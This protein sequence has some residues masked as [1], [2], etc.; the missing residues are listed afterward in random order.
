MSANSNQRRSQV[1][2][3]TVSRNSQIIRK[4]VDGNVSRS[5]E[6]WF[7]D[8]SIVL[9]VG[10]IMFRVHQ[11]VL[12]AHSEVFAGLFSLPQPAVTSKGQELIEGCHVVQ[13]HDPQ[14]DF[15]DLLKA[16]YRPGHLDQPPDNLEE[17]LPWISG[18]LR[19]STK[20]LIT[21]PRTR[22]ITILKAKFPV[23]FDEYNTLH[24][25]PTRKHYKSDDVMRAARLA[26]E[27]SIREILPY[28]FYGVARMGLA[29]IV[30]DSQPSVDISWK[31]KAICL[32]G[33][34]RLRWAE[35]SLSHS[36][37]FAFRPSPSCTTPQCA[38]ARGPHKEW[39]ILEAARAPNPLKAWTKWDAMNVC[40]E[41]VTF[42]QK[43]HQAGREEVW[44]HLPVIFELPTWDKL[45]EKA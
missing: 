29:R 22:C 15:I 39:R 7:H 18:I 21:S 2:D 37:L 34:E 28:I 43:Q 36:F 20:Y 8:G 32:V 24:A 10:S 17:L 23:T 33:R 26:Q 16:I 11:T 3:K 41:C 6:F 30:N 9:I 13:L 12:A 38:F 5:E 44:G 31:D 40:G 42:A 35:M 27:C 1:S 14:E 19:L 45:V 25:N 4:H